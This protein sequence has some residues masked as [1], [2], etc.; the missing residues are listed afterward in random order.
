MDDGAGSLLPRAVGEHLRYARNCASL[1]GMTDFTEGQRVKF[2]IDNLGAIMKA[3]GHCFEEQHFGVGDTGTVLPTSLVGD[4]WIEVE[5]D[6]HPE[7]YVPV[8]PGM[9]E[10]VS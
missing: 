4:G 8:H 9:I 7:L 10:A 6:G 5:P 2:T 3:G 1:A